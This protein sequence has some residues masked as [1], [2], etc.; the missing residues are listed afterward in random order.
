MPTIGFNRRKGV[1]FPNA[2]R[3][4]HSLLHT[5]AMHVCVGRS[6]KLDA[7]TTHCEQIK[8][9]LCGIKGE[10]RFF[11]LQFGWNFWGTQHTLLF[12]EIPQNRGQRSHNLHPFKQ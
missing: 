5:T 12:F 8:I 6:K 9:D 2:F 4:I 11:L 3:D 10:V 1:W 7:I